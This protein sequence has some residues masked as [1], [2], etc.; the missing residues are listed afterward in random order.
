MGFFTK[1]GDSI[2]GTFTLGQ[3]DGGGCGGHKAHSGSSGLLSGGG[4]LGGIMGGGGGGGGGG[5][6]LGGLT[7]GGGGGLLGGVFNMTGIPQLL[8][9]GLLLYIGIKVVFKLL[10]KI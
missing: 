2:A 8:M 9:E 1:L 4:L 10:D 3:C 5:G 7:G 6:L